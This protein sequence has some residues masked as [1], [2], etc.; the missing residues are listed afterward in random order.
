MKIKIIA[1]ALICMPLI[2]YAGQS[3]S[4]EGV[5]GAAVAASQKGMLEQ[6]IRCCDLISL[7]RQ[8]S[9]AHEPESVLKVLKAIDLSASKIILVSVD[10]RK[11]IVR[12]DGQ[13]QM[14]IELSASEQ[15]NSTPLYRITA[16]H[17]AKKLKP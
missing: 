9:G 7:S 15:T 10:K 11:A 13:V 1:L 3:L 12:I 4:P 17:P 8:K 2:G 14:Q 5:V 16:I 6:F